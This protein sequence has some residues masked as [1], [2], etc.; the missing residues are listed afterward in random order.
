MTLTVNVHCRE[1]LPLFF[2]NEEFARI[3]DDRTPLQLLSQLV[4]DLCEYASSR[5]VL[6]ANLKKLNVECNFRK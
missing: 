2:K 6:Y 1:Y 4:A 3:Q 5:F